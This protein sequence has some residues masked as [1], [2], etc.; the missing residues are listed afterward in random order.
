MQEN[1]AMP[2]SAFRLTAYLLSGCPFSMKLHIFLT[3]SGLCDGV[4]IVE[5]H[6]GDGTHLSLFSKVEAIGLKPSFPI[7]EYA[8][9]RFETESQVV[10]DR[11]ADEHAIDTTSLPLLTFYMDGMLPRYGKMFM[12]LKRLK[13]ADWNGEL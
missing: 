6:L 7:V 3:E 10:I 13:G 1:T 12:E 5:A 11:L 2:T 4:D 9:G 8:P